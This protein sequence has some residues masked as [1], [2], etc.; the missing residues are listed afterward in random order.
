MKNQTVDLWMQNEGTKHIFIMNFSVID[1]FK[2]ASRMPQTAQANLGLQNFPRGAGGMP[3][4]PPRLA[5]PGSGEKMSRTMKVKLTG[6]LALH[7]VYMLTQWRRVT[8]STMV[9]VAP[10]QSKKGGFFFFF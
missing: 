5:I 8:C 1:F 7:S 3:R 6:P 10:H 2:F 4:T 9:F